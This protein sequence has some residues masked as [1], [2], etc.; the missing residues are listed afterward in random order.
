MTEALP[1]TVLDVVVSRIDSDGVSLLGVCAGH[2]DGEWRYSQLVDDFLA[3]STDWVLTRADAQKISTATQ[4]ALFVKAITRIYQSSKYKNR[5]EVGELLLHMVMRKF[6]TGKAV[7]SRMWFKDAPNDTV[8]GYDGVF[9][10]EGEVVRTDGRKMLELWLGEAKLFTDAAAASRA[11]LD[12]LETHLSKDYLRTEFMAISDKV[13]DDW[14]HADEVRALLARTTSLDKVFERTVVPC[15]ITFDSN[16]LAAHAVSNETYVAEMTAHL[17]EEWE[18]F[19][20]RLDRRDLPRQVRI[21]LILMPM[22][23]KQ[24]LLEEFDRRLKLWQALLGA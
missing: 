6:L 7:I 20:H 11:V 16:V 3:W 24:K 4:H 10:T 23:T 17:E 21:H 1:S 12:E 5:G 18:A 14:E 22:N 9:V 13:E 19:K 2:E 8:K 15:F